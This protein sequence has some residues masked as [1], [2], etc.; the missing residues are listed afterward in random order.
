MLLRTLILI[1]A[2]TGCVEGPVPAQDQALRTAIASGAWPAQADGQHRSNPLSLDASDIVASIGPFKYTANTRYKYTGTTQ[3]EGKVT[4]STSLTVSKHGHFE[5]KTSRV[6]TGP[7]RINSSR[8]HHVIFNG[9]QLFLQLNGGAWVE[10]DLFHRGQTPWIER[11]LNTFPAMLSTLGEHLIQV[12]KGHQITL[13]MNANAKPKL[14]VGVSPDEAL[15][16]E[17]GTWSK[18]WQVTHKPQLIEGRIELNPT[19]GS[20]RTASVK[21]VATTRK[22]AVPSKALWPH[23]QVETETLFAG[24][25]QATFEASVSVQ[26]VPVTTEPKITAPAGPVHRLR[27]PRIQHMLQ[28]ILS[29]KSP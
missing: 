18:W 16:S 1:S 12:R 29:K 27:R 5:L 24:P 14:D 13:S 6:Y 17:G 11:A 28:Q 15:W 22:T 2:L 3:T 9:Q 19:Q 26:I 25:T 20:I 21:V 8:S 10:S 23:G 7:N 4:E